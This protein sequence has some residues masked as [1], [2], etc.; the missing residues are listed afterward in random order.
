MKE[1]RALLRD[2]SGRNAGVRFWGFV[3]LVFVVTA[4][5]AWSLLPAPLPE[6][7]RLGTGPVDGYYARFGEA[8]RKE[9]AK[10][11]VEIE[12]VTTTGS[13]ENIRLLE[14][15]E[16]DVGLLQ[17]GIQGDAPTTQLESIASVFYELVL[18]VER[19]DWDASHIEGGRIAIGPPGSGGNALSR[20]LLEDQGVRDGVPPGTQLVEIGG[21]QAVEA[22]RAGELD[23]GVLVTP[24]D[25]PEVRTLF[26]D[27]GLRVGDFTLAEAFTRYYPYLRRIVIPAGL[28]DL[29]L[30][31]PSTDVQAI[32]TTASLVIGPEAHRALIPLL[33]ESARAS[34]HQVSVLAAPGEFPSAL[35]VEAPL[36][37]EARLYFDRGP[38]FFYRWLP[39]RYASAAT[40][41]TIFL[42]P[43]LTLLYPLF[44]LA[45]PAYRALIRRR[46]YRWYKVLQ[47]I[48]GK[49]DSNGDAASL[50]EIR[51]EIER[52]GDQIRRTHVPASYGASL[53]ELRVHHR[54]LVDRLERFEQK[55]EP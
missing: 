34:R 22:L 38:S 33:I 50:L 10:Q 3:L 27:P 46:V 39:F 4:V 11:G 5:V 45:G 8:L 21:L 55:F 25:S 12:L 2:R 15:G 35:G 40:R 6:V 18:V 9:V 51:K 37:P 14:D 19:T 41:L 48:E 13:M 17:G 44:R 23:S 47:K 31:V 49:M 26:S 7:V 30:E 1:L 52:I 32:A 54:L 29:R 42:I 53:F 24:F 28:I 43:L 20:A 36:A 16:I